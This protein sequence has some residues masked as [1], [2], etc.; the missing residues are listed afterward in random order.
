MRN[1]GMQTIASAAALLISLGC[2]GEITSSGPGE[3]EPPV[4]E[5]PNPN[6]QPPA[7]GA[8]TIHSVLNGSF[9][10]LPG[11]SGIDGRVQLTRFLDGTTQVDLVATGLAAN[12]PHNA[13]V[14][15]LPCA[16]LG[17]G[18]YKMDPA[19]I[20]ALDTNEIWPNFISGEDGVGRASVT[21]THMARGDAMSVVIHDPAGGGKMACA[22]LVADDN[23]VLTAAGTIAPLP[24]V[25]LIDE[26]IGGS[27]VM[28]TTGIST[29]I[30]MSI[31]GLDPASDYV[32]HV[33]ALPCE[34]QTGGGHYMI[35]PTAVLVDPIDLEANELWPVIGAHDLGSA[36]VALTKAH[37]VRYDAQSIVIH[38][39]ELD[40]KPKVAC[41]NLVRSSWPAGITG[42]S[43]I[44]LDAGTE[45]LANLTA[46]AEMTRRLDG[47]TVVSMNAIGLE[48]D[49]T[50]AVH[51]HNL[52]C[53]VA[54]GGGHYLIDNTVA[55]TVQSNEI[56][57]RL[58]AGSDSAA[59]A[60][61]YA[62]HL[63]R[64]EASSLVIHD[65]ADGSRLACIDLH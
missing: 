45:R 39:V 5:T 52:P 40:T 29:K 4:D 6:A 62:S 1:R 25:A 53:G 44:L 51:V 41:V 8:A 33:H 27:A 34:V 28:T 57:L 31:T 56:W 3:E 48:K 11:F 60:T 13:H 16:Y 12:L 63:A 9:A 49:T 38:R 50:Y 59:E 61:T 32:S 47:V 20:D 65:P 55:D 10:P 36:T 35:D 21:V 43:A 64:A 24:G 30:D 37:N 14:H 18:H 2:T 46:T 17:G 54:S 15:A 22:D 7:E 26:T 58:T 42:G 19:I 23:G